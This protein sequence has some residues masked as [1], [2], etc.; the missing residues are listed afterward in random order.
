MPQSTTRRSARQKRPQAYKQK[1]NS[2]PQYRVQRF[3]ATFVLA[4]V[5][6]AS[7]GVY[8]A[9]QTVMNQA[10]TTKALT[11]GDNMSTITTQ[12]Q[13]NVG[14][15]LTNIPNASTLVSR[16]IS[17]ATAKSVITTAVSDVYTN[18]TGEIDFT[19]MDKAVKA[20]FSTGTSGLSATLA[21]GIASTVLDTLHNYFNDQLATR[22]QEARVH[23]QR[24]AEFLHTLILPLI[25]IGAVAAIWLLLVAGFGRFLHNLGW[26]GLVA[27][28]LGLGVLQFGQK[29]PV[30][31]ELTNKF[32]DFQLVA[33]DYIAQ[34]VNHMSGYYIIAAVAG[35]VVLLVTIPF[36]RSRR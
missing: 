25:I 16:A 15:S 28:L 24:A 6:F 33:A 34:V 30:F 35:L 21:A 32:G 3:F 36:S 12:V 19:D 9:N 11:S 4:L 14:S 5:A 2:R 1:T 26:A 20:A 17:T 23:Y 8:G 18:T 7:I 31:T 13:K 22:T 10:F 29:L 27:G